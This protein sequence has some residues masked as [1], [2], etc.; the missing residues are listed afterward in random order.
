MSK[1]DSLNYPQKDAVL[2]LIAEA[3]RTGERQADKL[4]DGTN[5]YAYPET[6]KV[7]WLANAPGRPVA[8]GAVTEGE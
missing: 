4:K 8:F 2:R 3:R 6:G 5:V 1:L 7:T